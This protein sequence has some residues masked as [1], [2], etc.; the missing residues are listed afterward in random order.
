[1]NKL[2]EPIPE[3]KSIKSKDLAIHA[4]RTRS[5]NQKATK[6]EYG[7]TQQ[8]GAG[9]PLKCRTTALPIS[10]ATSGYSKQ[11]LLTDTHSTLLREDQP[12]PHAFFPADIK[13]PKKQDND[14]PEL[15]CKHC[16]QP[17]SQQGSGSVDPCLDGLKRVGSHGT[18]H[19]VTGLHEAGGRP[20][21]P[22]H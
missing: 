17:S 21:V 14:S 1:M 11:L 8:H 7:H 2:F 6:K 18:G 5:S 13:L 9:S 10:R 16:L 19:Q 15:D 22:R 4:H 20:K 12:H 3:R